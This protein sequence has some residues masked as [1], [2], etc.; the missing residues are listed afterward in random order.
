MR[1]L[2][3]ITQ[4]LG[5]ANC[6]EPTLVAR[7]RA[8][9]ERERREGWAPYAALEEEMATLLGLPAGLGLLARLAAEIRGGRFD[10]NAT[11]ETWLWRY[12]DQRLR[13]NDPDFIIDN[14]MI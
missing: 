12:V 9:A 7:G 8:I 3:D 14:I 13:E 5:L 10:D 1:D 11:V 4:I 6:A 2:P